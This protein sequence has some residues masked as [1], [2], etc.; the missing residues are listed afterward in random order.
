VIP[1]PIRDENPSY[2]TPVVTIVIIALNVL[3]WFYELSTRIPCPNGVY[4][5]V[6]SAIYDYGAIPSFVLSGVGEGR[7][8]VGEC[9]AYL[10]LHQPVP[11]ALTILTSMFL[12]GGWLH[13]LGNMWFLWIFGDNIEDALGKVRF[14]IFYLLCG[15]AAA[16]AQILTSA[17]STV[18]MVGASGA[19][20]GVLGGYLLLYPRARVRCLWILIIFITTIDLPAWL[21]LGLWFIS[22]FF[23]PQGEGIAWMAH[24]GGFITGFGLIRLFVRARPLRPRRV[25]PHTL[26]YQ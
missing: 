10:T 14:S 12:H 16:M 17:H 20:A 15:V 7:V 2:R 5:Q 8:P 18:P 9:G 19:I 13:I 6:M 4:H 21:L 24:V 23:V 3:A 1:L 25:D 26:E 22:Q 11:P